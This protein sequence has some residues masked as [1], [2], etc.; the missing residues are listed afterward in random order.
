ME[1]IRERQA[2]VDKAERHDLLSNLL[3]ENDHDLKTLTENEIISVFLILLFF[4]IVDLVTNVP[5]QY[6]RLPCC[7][8]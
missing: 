6:L 5:R 7:C 1:M 3:E 2:M 8:T 4:N